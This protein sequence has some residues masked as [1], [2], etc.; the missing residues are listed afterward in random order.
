MANIKGIKTGESKATPY[1]NDVERINFLWERS[2]IILEKVKKDF[3]GLNA[4]DANYIL[5]FFILSLY[6]LSVKNVDL[7]YSVLSEFE[8]IFKEYLRDFLGYYK[9]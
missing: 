7:R 9:N 8:E 2:Q 5:T 6:E 4:P 3:E 1:E